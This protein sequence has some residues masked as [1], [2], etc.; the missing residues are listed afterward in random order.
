MFSAIP[1][2]TQTVF[3]GFVALPAR[4][5][6]TLGHLCGWGHV[7]S[8]W[9]IFEEHVAGLSILSELRILRMTYVDFFEW[10]K[11]RF[12]WIKYISLPQ[13][14]SL[15]PIKKLVGL[16]L[17]IFASSARYGEEICYDPDGEMGNTQGVLAAA[18]PSIVTAAVR[19]C[20]TLDV[21]R[22]TNGPLTKQWLEEALQLGSLQAFAVESSHL[23][24]SCTLRLLYVEPKDGKPERVALKG[25]S[26]PAESRFY[27]E[28]APKISRAG[29]RLPKIFYNQVSEVG[30]SS[31]LMEDFSDL[32]PLKSLEDL[33]LALAMLGR[34]HAATFGAAELQQMT[35]NSAAA[36]AEVG[37]AFQNWEEGS[38]LAARLLAQQD[39]LK[40]LPKGLG[41]MCVI[42]GDAGSEKFL[43]DRKTSEI[44]PS[45][46]RSWRVGSPAQDV[47][48]LLSN[49]P[50]T[51][52]LLDQL[53]EVYW[54]SFSAAGELSDD[55]MTKVD[56]ESYLKISCL[57]VALLAT[58]GHLEGRGRSW[59]LTVFVN[60]CARITMQN[61]YKPIH[62]LCT[63]KR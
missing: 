59:C 50:E 14:L 26:S 9:G 5:H 42:L 35:Q 41:K 48:S 39:L 63:L 18:S 57:Q 61:I 11:N 15:N 21:A 58:D 25:S 8:G 2:V 27:E 13:D 49:M 12:R 24:N 23:K 36:A 47:A 20:S 22:G 38:E 17:K 43:I 44:I 54:L 4:R 31:L 56:F 6:I 53:L 7:G 3:Q 37:K 62:L 45:D 19:V 16:S 51:L 55:R 32:D 30:T 1:W 52:H 33:K 46:F 10:L 40:R 34:F 28:C 29:L 60:V